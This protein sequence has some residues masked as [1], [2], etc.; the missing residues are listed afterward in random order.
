M[1]NYFPED[2]R[3]ETQ[4]EMDEFHKAVGRM[5][6]A[7]SDR[8]GKDVLEY[9]EIS[10]LDRGTELLSVFYPPLSSGDT[11]RGCNKLTD[12][13]AI[14]QKLARKDL[15]KAFVMGGIKHEPGEPWTFHS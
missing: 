5:V 8:S 1:L 15:G 7:M 10:I 11:L 12:D 3:F 2:L 14:E 13:V 9:V 6:M 4:A